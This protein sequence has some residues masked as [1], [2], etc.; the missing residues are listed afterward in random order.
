MDNVVMKGQARSLGAFRVYPKG[1]RKKFRIK[2][3]MGVTA[4]GNF[5]QRLKPVVGHEGLTKI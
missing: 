3:E 4:H 1:E 2:V 5:D